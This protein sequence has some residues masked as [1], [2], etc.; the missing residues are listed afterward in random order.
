MLPKIDSRGQIDGDVALIAY[1]W[2]SQEACTQT[3]NSADPDHKWNSYWDTITESFCI[4]GGIGEQI[5]TVE[6]LMIRGKCGS[7][8]VIGS[9][10]PKEGLNLW[11]S[12]GI[13]GVHDKLRMTSDRKTLVTAPRSGGTSLFLYSAQTETELLHGD[14]GSPFYT[15]PDAGGEVRIVGIFFGG[16]SLLGGEVGPALF[17]SWE[18]AEKILDLEPIY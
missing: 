1:P 14:S 8:K 3:F 11:A 13:S 12:G 18:D 5:E 6:P 17:T 9:E 16:A 4:R 2:Q 10:K 15:V 7:Y